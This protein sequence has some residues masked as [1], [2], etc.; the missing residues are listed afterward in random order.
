MR[1]E[2]IEEYQSIIV[3][4]KNYGLDINQCFLLVGCI[5]CHELCLLH[6]GGW[7]MEVKVNIQV[8]LITLD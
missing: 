6:V 1:Q 4:N 5:V 7:G 3:S 8:V 2:R